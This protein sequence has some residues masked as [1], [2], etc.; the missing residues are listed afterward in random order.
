MNVC[1]MAIFPVTSSYWFG[2]LVLFGTAYLSGFVKGWFSDRLSDF[3]VLHVGEF[4]D[5]VGV[6]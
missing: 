5:E 4:R 1:K 3:A 2:C 6:E